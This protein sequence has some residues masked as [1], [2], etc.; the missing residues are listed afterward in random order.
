AMG[1]EDKA[2][3]AQ[4][5]WPLFKALGQSLERDLYLAQLAGKVG[6]DTQQLEARLQAAE[7]EDRKASRGQWPRQT[8]PTS[9]GA[10]QYVPEDTDE[11]SADG[12]SP[13][14]DGR[15]P[16]PEDRFSD[17]DGP[18]PDD[19]WAPPPDDYGPA[20]PRQARP[21]PPA[22]EPPKPVPLDEELRA[23]TE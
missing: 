22:K 14:A 10:A 5:L 3:A 6:V 21:A 8:R 1:V 19:R 18:P 17:D 12:R 9:G 20:E 23:V 15:G 2:R 16:R 7:K 4:G 13:R 11:V